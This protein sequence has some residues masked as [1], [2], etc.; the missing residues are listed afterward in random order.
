[1]AV[2]ER[3]GWKAPKDAELLLR[4]AYRDELPKGYR[5]GTGGVV[6]QVSPM[7]RYANLGGPVDNWTRE[8]GFPVAMG[9]VPH[10]DALTIHEAVMALE[11]VEI[12]WPSGA[13]ELLGDLFQYLTD[14]EQFAMQRLS[15]SP[16]AL[17]T[18]HARLGNRPIWEIDYN[19]VRVIGRSRKSLLRKGRGRNHL[20]M[21]GELTTD[22]P[23]S[24]I[25]TARFEY[26]A[27]HVSLNN[28]AHTLRLRDHVAL[29]PAAPLAPW[30]EPDR[31]RTLTDAVWMDAK[32][33]A[34][35]RLTASAA[36]PLQPPRRRVQP[37]LPAAR[38]GPVR[39]LRPDG[40]E[41]LT[42]APDVA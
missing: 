27:W 22:V 40:S 14:T 23:A 5:E 31:A 16:A 6:P 35:K 25:L 41:V 8:P 13:T 2:D 4:W 42:T 17:I 39:R 30:I 18:M 28:L 26:L 21:Q 10:P 32:A 3:A 37:Q 29:P 38:H 20:K 34:N 1:M 24:E 15:T 12:A 36:L 9:T 33:L 19:I 11:P 7:F